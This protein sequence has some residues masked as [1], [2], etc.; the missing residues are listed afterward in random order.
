MK[1]LESVRYGAAVPAL[2]TALTVGCGTPTGPGDAPEKITELPRA[3]TGA[4]VQLLGASNAFGVDM[5]RVLAPDHT[6]DNLFFSPLSASMALGMTLNGA[7]GS[8]YDQMAAT[9]GFDG[10]DQGAINEAYT[11]LLELLQKLDPAVTVDIANSVWYRQGVEVDASFVSRVRNA[12]KAE[13]GGVDFADPATTRRINDWVK[14]RTK[15]TIPKLV[16]QLPPNLVML[17]MNAV[18]FKGDWTSAFDPDR[19]TTGT[20]AAPSGPVDAKFMSQRTVARLG[21]GDGV[22]LV[23]LPYGGQAFAM[24]LIL[25]TDG[26]DPVDVLEG[27]DLARWNSWMSNAAE[28]ELVVELPRFELTWERT[29]NP[30]LQA[31]GMRDAF[32]PGAAD[33]SRM[34]PGGGVWIDRVL[35][36]SFIRVDEKGT[37]ASAV[38]GVF[39]VE[40]LP[41]TIRFDRPFVLAIRERLSGTLLFMG[42]VRDPS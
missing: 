41:P 6:D 11:S 29:L 8:T 2:V 15:G 30:D 37:E 31:L 4:E 10:V 36:K 14:D 12:F 27:V 18:Y 21:E 39:V 34:I 22:Q 3:L 28:R 19:T 13:V 40:S 38:T 16:D 26:A 5:L 25:P 24:T 20:F 7:A 17:L 1:V 9:L 33:F 32:D 23:E 35:Q 42:V